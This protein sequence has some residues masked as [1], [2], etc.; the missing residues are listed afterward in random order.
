[1]PHSFDEK[2]ADEIGLHAAI[3]YNHIHCLR[4]NHIAEGYL[5]AVVGGYMTDKEVE[6]AL[7]K[8]EDSGR[9]KIFSTNGRIYLS[10]V[11]S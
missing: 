8:L 1:M 6:Y 5:T 11:V 7:K 2:I 3:I 10:G 9:I 4:C